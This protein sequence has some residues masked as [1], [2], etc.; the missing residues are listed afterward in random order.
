MQQRIQRF[1]RILKLRENDR[2]TE[3]ITLSEQKREEN[4]VQ[5]YLQTL[6]DE[7]CEALQNFCANEGKSFSCQDLWFRR[8]AI[9]N[10]DKRI[11]AGKEA[12]SEVQFKIAG[13]ETRLVERH[14]D[15]RVMESYLD[16]LK[17]NAR[18]VFFDAEQ[19]ELDDIAMMRYSYQA[20]GRDQ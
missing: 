3:Q 16:L 19:T 2:K 7:K 13:T 6:G 1:N 5:H 9:E 11:D 10:L 17:E 12:L 20:K 4:E 18:K 8:Q 14:K 15:V